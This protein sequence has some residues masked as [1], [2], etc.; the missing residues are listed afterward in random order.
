MAEPKIAKS[1]RHAKDYAFDPEGFAKDFPRNGKT[2][3]TTDQAV[4]KLAAHLGR[5]MRDMKAWGEDVRDD[6]VRLEAAV[7]VAPGDPG[8]PPPAPRAK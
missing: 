2:S 8:D 6:I 1:H 4:N 7:H 3:L 5:W